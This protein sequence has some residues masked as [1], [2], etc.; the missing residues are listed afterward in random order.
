M[1][2]CKLFELW[3]ILQYKEKKKLN[4]STQETS[5]CGHK[6]EF[7]AKISSLIICFFVIIFGKFAGSQ[8]AFSC[9]FYTKR[10]SACRKFSKMKNYSRS[11]HF[12]IL[13]EV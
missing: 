8:Q 2:H 5:G 9:H 7:Y 11:F 1:S 13:T 4:T 3:D 10:R 6:V 12:S